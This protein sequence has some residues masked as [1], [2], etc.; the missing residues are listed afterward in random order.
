MTF[1]KEKLAVDIAHVKDRFI[2]RERTS[3]QLSNQYFDVAVKSLDSVIE[4]ATALPKYIAALEE[5][6]RTL[7]SI[8]RDY[9]ELSHDKVR[10]QR[11]DYMRYAKEALTTIRQLARG[12]E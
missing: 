11:D 5:A 6:E 3:E 9:I 2:V 1:T 8:A 10:V 4:A 12:K 7:E